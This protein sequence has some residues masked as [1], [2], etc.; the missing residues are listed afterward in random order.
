MRALLGI[1]AC[2]VLA[3]APAACSK[4]R[5]PSV[6]GETNWL[7]RCSD[8]APCELG[9]CLCGVCSQPCD[10]SAVCGGDFAGSCTSSKV[11]VG[12]T[13]CGQRE[14]PRGGGLCL[15]QCRT[16]ATCGERFS[17]L[18]EVCVPAAGELGP[19][20]GPANGGSSAAGS[21][22]AGGTAV[23]DG[24]PTAGDGCVPGVDSGCPLAQG[25]GPL[26]ER[27]AESR[28]AWDTLAASGGETYWYE[29][30]NCVVN[31]AGGGGDATVVQVED[32]VASLASMGPVDSCVVK[33]NRYG[34]LP[35]LT[36][37]GLYDLCAELLTFRGSAI[38]LTTDARGVVQS[39]FTP[40]EPGCFD[41]CGSGFALG[42]WAFG[43]P[44]PGADAG[45]R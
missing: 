15:P 43:F 1:L 14:Q 44:G 26:L 19:D 13:L 10:E 20:G 39:C 7:V 3:L 25:A 45:A 40:D 29:E 11:G 31:V 21:G 41:A 18:D 12:A 5:S 22:G 16:D 42:G 2:T 8:D 6:G 9:S 4:S 17:C 32:G 24:G 33:V 23:P 34:G 35:T 27:L 38:T 28:Q 37:N 30:Q 36:M